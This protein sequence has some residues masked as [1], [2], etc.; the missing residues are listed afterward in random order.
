MQTLQK[1]Y[2]YHHLKQQL[3]ERNYVCDRE[4]KW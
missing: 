1:N 4:K 3:P 2:F